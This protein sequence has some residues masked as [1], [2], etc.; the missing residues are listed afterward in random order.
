MR[1]RTE[2][3]GE[4]RDALEAK[5]EALT[6]ALDEALRQRTATGDILRAIASSPGNVTP[7]LDK[8][9]EAACRLCEAY[10][11]IVLLREGD[12]LRIAAHHGPIPLPPNIGRR[13]I[14]RD[15]PPGRAVVDRKPVHVHDLAAAQDEF[16]VAVTFSTSAA[17]GAPPG[18]LPGLAWRT[19]LAMPL[20]REAEALGVIVLRRAEVQPFSDGQI[21]LLQ[22]FADQAA[23]AIQN[24]GLFG[25]IQ[26]ALERETATSDILR[27]ISQ[28]PTDAQTGVR[29]RSSSPPRGRYAATS[30]SCC[31]AMATSTSPRPAR[32]RR[33]Q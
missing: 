6:R 21:A 7:V 27:V 26:E 4:S 15:W 17:H 22:T 13:P 3:A 33:V 25:E 23:I 9:T 8:L 1:R 28:S 24:A 19:A 12:D 18:A 20:M 32:R 2:Q 30:H 5:V 10:D 31:C 11:A 14:G 16:P 29:T